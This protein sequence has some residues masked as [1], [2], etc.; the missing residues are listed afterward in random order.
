[1]HFNVYLILTSQVSPLNCYFSD[2]QKWELL[3]A[4]SGSNCGW[5]K[6]FQQSAWKLMGAFWDAQFPDHGA[7]VK[8]TISDTMRRCKLRCVGRCKHEDLNYSLV[9]SNTL[10]NKHTCKTPSYVTM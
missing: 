3:V 6:H 2:P 9:R 1:M 4:R 10:Y 7:T 5:A 8:K